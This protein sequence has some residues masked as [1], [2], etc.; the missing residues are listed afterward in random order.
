[1]NLRTEVN[2]VKLTLIDVNSKEAEGAL[3]VPAIHPDVLPCHEAHIGIVEE[4]RCYHAGRGIRPCC[5]ALNVGNAEHTVEVGDRGR[6]H[7][8]TQLDVEWRSRQRLRNGLGQCRH[9]LCGLCQ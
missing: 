8:R 2:K 6:L 5:G 9:G 3:V 1:M 7:I 4:P